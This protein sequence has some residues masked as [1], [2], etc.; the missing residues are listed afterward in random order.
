MPTSST[1][2]RP[3]TSKAPDRV[4]AGREPSSVSTQSA[5]EGI[6][7]PNL[8]I[9]RHAR[10]PNPRESGRLGPTPRTT[11]PQVRCLVTAQVGIRRIVT[12]STPKPNSGANFGAH[13]SR[14]RRQNI[15]LRRTGRWPPSRLRPSRAGRCRQCCARP[16]SEPALPEAPASATGVSQRHRLGQ[17]PVKQCRPKGAL[18]NQVDGHPDDS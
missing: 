9:R 13:G 5:P 8:L 3:G 16:R 1:A 7:T 11:F 15:G 4:S 10:G 18:R 14:P 17:I 2:R 12:V 6:R